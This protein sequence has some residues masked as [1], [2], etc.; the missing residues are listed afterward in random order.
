MSYFFLHQLAKVW[1][2]T[3]GSG[4]LRTRYDWIKCEL[5]TFIRNGKNGYL[6]PFDT[7]ED[8]VDDVVTKLAHAIVM[9]FNNGPQTPHDIYSTT[10]YDSRYYFKMGNISSRGAA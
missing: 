1:V 4:R 9:Y 7:D 5:V 2:N 10:I 8:S 3:N 6:V